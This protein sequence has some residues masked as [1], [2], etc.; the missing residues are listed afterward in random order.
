MSRPGRAVH[1]AVV[2]HD[3]TGRVTASSL[4]GSPSVPEAVARVLHEASPA[5]QA[6]WVAYRRGTGR[7]AHRSQVAIDDGCLLEVTAVPVQTPRQDRFGFVVVATLRREHESLQ[8]LKSSVIG[9]VSH[10]VR[11]PLT[12]ISVC[13]EMLDD[14]S[15]TDRADE[16]AGVLA[17]ARRNTARLAEIA[18][19]IQGLLCRPI[20]M[21][22]TD[23]GL[24]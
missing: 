16:F 8:E 4:R 20:E 19:D 14:F 9:I 15:A 5:I 2:T 3:A 17:I 10:E 11:T 1:V 18:D 13:L 21:P 24:G 12:C 7:E 6:W 23:T 22:S